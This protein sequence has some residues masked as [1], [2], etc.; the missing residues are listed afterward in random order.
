[1][2][3]YAYVKPIFLKYYKFIEVVL[4]FRQ[5]I[6]SRKWGIMQMEVEGEQTL[7]RIVER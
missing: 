7:K 1:M 4:S 2:M 5:L 3:T 6:K